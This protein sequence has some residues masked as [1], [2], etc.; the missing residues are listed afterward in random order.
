MIKATN[1]REL[2]HNCFTQAFPNVFLVLVNHHQ[3]GSYIQ[4]STG[5]SI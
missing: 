2:P 5:A 1:E 3:C 4:K